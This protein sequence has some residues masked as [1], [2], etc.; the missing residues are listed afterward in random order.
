MILCKLGKRN[1]GGA[2]LEHCFAIAYFTKLKTNTE[3]VAVKPIANFDDIKKRQS[4]PERNTKL[5]VNRE[6]L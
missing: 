5:Y 4:S 3:K 2:N 1:E 6:G